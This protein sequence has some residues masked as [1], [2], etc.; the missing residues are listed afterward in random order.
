MSKTPPVQV[1]DL[2]V[3]VTA[4]ERGIG[5][6]ERVLDDGRHRVFFYP[7]GTFWLGPAAE[8]RPCP[9]GFPQQTG[10]VVEGDG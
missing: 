6:L 5:R 9:V 10:F 7:T 1:G 4:P 8:V 2:V 3:I